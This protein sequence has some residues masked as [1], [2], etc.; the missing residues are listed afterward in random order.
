MEFSITPL[1]V[2]SSFV[3]LLYLV[4]GRNPDPES[5]PNYIVAFSTGL[6]LT[7][8]AMYFIGNSSEETINNVMREIDLADPDF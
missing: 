7:V 1:V 5:K 8:V 2:A 6:V 4:K 3:I